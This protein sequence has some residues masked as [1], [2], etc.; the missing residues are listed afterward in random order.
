ML[1]V[2]VIVMMTACSPFGAPADY[3]DKKEVR[4]CI[5]TYS[6]GDE[7]SSIPVCSQY[8][9]SESDMHTLNEQFGYAC[10]LYRKFIQ[11]KGYNVPKETDLDLEIYLTTYAH[12]ND[13]EYF[14]RKNKS[15]HIVGRYVSGYANIFITDRVLKERAN[16]DFPHELAHWFNDILEIE[17]RILNEQLATE[18]EEYYVAE[19]R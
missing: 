5:H 9:L 7:V 3:Y 14:P 19:T 1:S 2:A 18:F 17:N 10:F 16:T 6:V 15:A 8:P 4:Y 11:A 12:I 13:T